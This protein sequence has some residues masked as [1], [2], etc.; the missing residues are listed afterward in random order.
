MDDL[1]EMVVQE[2]DE[3]HQKQ[4]AEAYYWFTINEFVELILQYGPQQVLPDFEKQ[5]DKA[6]SALMTDKKLIAPQ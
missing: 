4:M 2:D 6:R 3:Q 1:N 5:M